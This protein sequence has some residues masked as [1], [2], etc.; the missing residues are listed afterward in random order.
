MRLRS[1]GL[2]RRELVL[3][4]REY[5]LVRTE[6]EVVIVGTIRDPV[7]WD[8]SIRICQDDIPGMAGLVLRRVMIGHLL[9]GL[10]RRRRHHHWGQERPEHLA[11]GKK[12]RAT[13][14]Q[15]AAER[16][17]GSL[18][19]LTTRRGSAAVRRAMPAAGNG[20]T[21]GRLLGTVEKRIP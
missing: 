3:D 13:A 9:R 5:E 19:P 20:T 17:R 7:T 1:R 15:N 14:L 12:R 4:F 8:F 11:E 21:Q 2:G 18:H 10:F 16:A 6:D